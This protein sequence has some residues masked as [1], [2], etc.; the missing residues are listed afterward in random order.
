MK[1]DI[2]NNY[3]GRA[4]V[5]PNSLRVFYTF[6]SGENDIIWNNVYTTGEHF[7]EDGTEGAS[8]RKLLADRFPGLSIGYTDYPS[9]SGIVGHQHTF[10]LLVT[11]HQHL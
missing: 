3:L 10:S 7:C 1:K 5:D 9:N 2:L 4:G 8:S 11:L 6:S